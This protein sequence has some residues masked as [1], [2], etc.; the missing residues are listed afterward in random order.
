MELFRISMEAYAKGLSASG[1]ANRWNKSGEFVLYAGS[2]RSLASL[3]LVVH[4]AAIRPLGNYKV[5]VIS[6]ADEDKLVRQ[7]H[8]DELPASWRTAAAYPDLQK[9]GSNWYRNKETLLLKVPSAV[10]IREY[11]YLINIGHPAFVEKVSLVRNEDY[12]W[13]ERL[14]S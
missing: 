3:E 13:D 11:N 12:F 10:I 8:L 2:S 4:R 6:V 14:L 9:L 1:S 5:M 7:V